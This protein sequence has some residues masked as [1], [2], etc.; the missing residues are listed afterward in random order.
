MSTQYNKT[1]GLYERERKTAQQRE[2]QNIAKLLEREAGKDR[3]C[4]GLRVEPY[5]TK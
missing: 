2:E 1:I 5:Y 3:C 4:G